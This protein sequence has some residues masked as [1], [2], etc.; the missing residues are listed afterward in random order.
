MD[1]GITEVEDV[2]EGIAEEVVGVVVIMVDG[3]AVASVD[4]VVGAGEVSPP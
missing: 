1:G 4:V 3:S 2:V